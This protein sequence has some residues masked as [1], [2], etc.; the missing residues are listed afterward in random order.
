MDLTK[1]DV[2]LIVNAVQG[3]T[4]SRNLHISLFSGLH[5]WTIP[6]DATVAVRYRKP[7]HTKGYYDT[8]PDGTSAWSAQ[9]N[10]LTIW[11]APQ[12]LTV[13]GSVKVQIELIQ[14]THIL[15]TFSLIVYVEA[16]P[17]AGILTSEDYCNWLQWFQDQSDARL[18]LVQQSADIS[19]QASQAAGQAAENA[20]NE[21]ASA[22]VSAER[23]MESAGNAMNAAT[24]AAAIREETKAVAEEVSALVAGIN[25]YTKA[26]SDHR[27]S[28]AIL[29][30]IAGDAIA[31]SDALDMELQGLKLFGKTTYSGTP[32]PE[33]PVNLVHAGDT[34]TITLQIHGENLFYIPAGTE[35]T[36]YGVT[37]TVQPDGSIRI[38]GTKTDS[39][40]ANI[41]Y[42]GIPAASY[43]GK[44]ITLR[45]HMANIRTQANIQLKDGT[46]K[47][48]NAKN[49]TKTFT[50]PSDA[51]FIGWQVSIDGLDTY[52][53]TIFYPYAVFGA[54]AAPWVP[55][56]TQIL[57]A[58]TPNGLSGIP[59]SSGGNYTDHTGQQWICDE[60]D[61]GRGVHVQRVYHIPLDANVFTNYKA[62]ARMVGSRAA[63]TIDNIPSIAGANGTGQAGTVMLSNF[64]NIIGH[65]AVG[66]CVMWENGTNGIM[67]CNIAF[68]TQ[69]V[70]EATKEAFIDFFRENP[71]EILI[72][73][74]EPIETVLSTEALAAYAALH[75]NYTDTTIL[76]NS[77]AG[78][79]ITYMADTKRYMDNMFAQ[80][81]T[82]SVNDT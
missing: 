16:N 20:S 67:Q 62:L 36:M 42:N 58:S 8:L 5:P 3:D 25:A 51:K 71:G 12:M 2:S 1:R 63:V 75:T 41:Y 37:Q 30:S 45:S 40:E 24:S 52:N 50:I 78:M 29:H 4:Y 27:Y 59:V 11:L 33:A 18:L 43:A 21:S 61:F 46:W 44:T 15:S 47:H 28:P 82:A 68:D 70:A 66:A 72:G 60:L 38:N 73:M 9:K 54:K 34:G 80:L 65:N 26:E 6:E 14:G 22:A 55:G 13:P 17:A 10:V 69:Y 77:G 35:M 39:R 57:A 53:D 49:N 76:N 56:V 32:T 79:E 19:T 48:L 23:A 7:D 64:S 31:L 74:P 81:A